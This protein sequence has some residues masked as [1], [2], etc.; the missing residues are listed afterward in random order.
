M[1][2]QE[3]VDGFREETNQLMQE[4]TDVVEKLE[5]KTK[6]FPTKL[7]EEFA[8][9]IDRIMGA[10]KT[11]SLMEPNHQGL[12]RMG[13]LAEICKRLGYKA[14][15]IKNPVVL[16]LFAAFWADVIEVIQDLIGVMHDDTKS[17]GIS[18]AFGSVLQKRLEWL[19][20]QIT[21]L[22]PKIQA[23]EAQS[24]QAGV[25]FNLEDLLKDLGV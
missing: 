9:K 7:L 11:I 4:L 23:Q 20:K 24:K 8:L 13:S 15:E 16:P 12:V 1:L 18:K 5:I 6:E 17:D 21:N 22:S 14:A 10:A 3:I 19:S 25:D 2:D